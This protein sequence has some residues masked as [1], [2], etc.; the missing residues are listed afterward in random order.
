MSRMGGDI[1]MSYV[2]PNRMC[3]S[4]FSRGAMMSSPWIYEPVEFVKEHSCSEIK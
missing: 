3:L 4:T 2:I 1:T